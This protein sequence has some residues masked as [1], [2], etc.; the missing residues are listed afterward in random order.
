[1]AVDKN[2]SECEQ[3]HGDE[4]KNN[5][6]GNELEGSGNDE[7]NDENATSSNLTKR[8][9]MAAKSKVEKEK[10]EEMRRFG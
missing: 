1:M 6:M 7:N 10:V 5:V 8:Q 9:E 4:K 2:P 3:L